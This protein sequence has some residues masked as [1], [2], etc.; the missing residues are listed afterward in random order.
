MI[1]AIKQEGLSRGLP[2]P[3]TFVLD[4]SGRCTHC[5]EYLAVGSRF[6]DLSPRFENDPIFCSP[7][8]VYDEYLMEV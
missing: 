7:D 4:T 3:D 1:S 8:C 5:Q 2:R 6:W